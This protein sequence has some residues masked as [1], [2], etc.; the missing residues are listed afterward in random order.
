MEV[1]KKPNLFII[2]APKCGT[3]SLIH[4]L[5]QHPEVFVSP[6]KEPHF[7]N[8]DSGHRYYFDEKKYLDL[9]S[10]SQAQHTYSCEGSVWYLYSKVAVANILE[11]NPDAKFIVLL[12]NPVKMYF[13]LHRELLFGGSENVSSPT[14]A[15]ALQEDRK[16]GAHIPEHCSDPRLLQYGD[17]CKL[18]K[19]VAAI[20][21][22][23]PSENL[24]F[25]FL[26]DMASDPDGTFQSVLQFLKAS[27]LHLPSYEVVNVKK[28]RKYRMLSKFFIF[29][30]GLKKKLGIKGGLG[31]ASAINKHNVSHDVPSNAE[32]VANLSEELYN[33][34]REDI[35]LLET[36]TNR[37]LAHWNLTQTK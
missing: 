2:G 27:M 10:K 19:Q 30:T 22:K 15:W 23:I 1:V 16:M 9:F 32:E 6:I 5:S 24:K 37:N 18:G 29:T 7:F 31:L 36:I 26:D 4:Y 17:A 11:F 25:V 14:K 28:V 12:R 20:V 3:T 13:S 21:D 8:E 34:F 33:F 35:A